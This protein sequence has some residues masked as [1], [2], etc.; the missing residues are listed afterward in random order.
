MNTYLNLDSDDIKVTL[1]INSHIKKLKSDISNQDFKNTLLELDNIMDS[2]LC[3]SDEDLILDCFDKLHKK[4]PNQINFFLS[5]I[6]PMKRGETFGEFMNF[7]KN[8]NY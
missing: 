2:E 7:L 4:C 3:E 8:I 5:E 1:I 6:T